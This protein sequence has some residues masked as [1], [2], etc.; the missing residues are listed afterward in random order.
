MTDGLGAGA[1]GAGAIGI[2]AIAAGT[3]AFEDAGFFFAWCLA[4]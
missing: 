4:G 1:I 2:G 3:L